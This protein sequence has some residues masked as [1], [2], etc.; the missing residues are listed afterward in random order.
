[1]NFHKLILDFCKSCNEIGQSILGR[2][3][4]T[5]FFNIGFTRRIARTFIQEFFEKKK[6]K[7]KKKKTNKQEN[8]NFCPLCRN[9]NLPLKLNLHKF[10]QIKNS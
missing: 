4:K 1:M 3:L 9:G 2:T 8:P 6:K 10:L 7:K 5:K